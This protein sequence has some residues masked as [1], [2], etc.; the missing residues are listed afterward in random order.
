M[1]VE[2]LGQ[3]NRRYHHIGSL[4]VLCLLLVACHGEGIDP[5]TGTGQEGKPA[6]EKEAPIFLG[7]IEYPEEGS[8]KQLSLWQVDPGKPKLSLP[9]K[10]LPGVPRQIVPGNC[11][12]TFDRACANTMFLVV[13]STAADP[14]RLKGATVVSVAYASDWGAP[15]PGILGGQIVWY[16]YRK[17]FYLVLFKS[18]SHALVTLSIHRIDPSQRIGTYPLNLES[19]TSEEWPE[20]TPQLSELKTNL[21]HYDESMV[22]G[23]SRIDVT[24]GW[25]PRSAVLLIRAHGC[26]PMGD[27]ISQ[28]ITF[29]FD[30][31]TKKWS[32]LTWT[33]IEQK[34]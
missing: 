17:T 23:L 4:V 32:A 3:W 15:A 9:P 5:D 18:Q 31:R 27:L 28:P 16:P 34:Q 12:G 20:P 19:K 10:K 22:A 26:C 11:G 13:D 8:S 1:R 21:L 24:A 30:L 2:S 7:S 33:E 6:P 29:R 14:K 25:S